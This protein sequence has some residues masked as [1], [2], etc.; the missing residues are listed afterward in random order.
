ML[1]RIAR[2]SIACLLTAGGIYAQP[3]DAERRARRDELRDGP[4]REVHKLSQVPDGTG[5]VRYDPGVPADAMLNA[6]TTYGFG[7][8]FDTRSG[9]PLS[10]PGTVTFVSWYHGTLPTAAVFIFPPG[11]TTFGL[12]YS[13]GPAPP[14]TFVGINVA[15][16]VPGAFVGGL[17]VYSGSF[18]SVGV[19][20]ATTNA[21][22]FHGVQRLFNGGVS[23]TLPGQNVMIRVSG[24]VI[25]PV[26][27]LEFEVE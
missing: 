27:L 2:V 9:S 15:L 7:N 12:A 23:N 21:Q 8:L 3:T 6:P 16:S 26:E 19:R 1:G 14:L 13:A 25:I 24:N 22:G 11:G 17:F 10:F 4:R 5:T 20:S 18:A